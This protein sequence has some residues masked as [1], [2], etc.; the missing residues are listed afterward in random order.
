MN[1]YSLITYHANR[2]KKTILSNKQMKEIEKRKLHALKMNNYSDLVDAKEKVFKIID[3][4]GLD[5]EDKALETAIK[6]LPYIAAQKKSI[7]MN[8][9]SRKLEDIISEHIEEATII[10]DDNKADD[11]KEN[12]DNEKTS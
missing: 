7:E 11:N 1:N 2:G 5:N 12:A 9:I 3:E 6:I 8:V 10:V 4:K